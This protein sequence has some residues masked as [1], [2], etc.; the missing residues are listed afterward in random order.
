MKSKIQ[1]KSNIDTMK[2]QN[3]NFIKDKT[4]T[5]KR[6][7]KRKNV[8]AQKNLKAKI[9]NKKNK[10]SKVNKKSNINKINNK[11]NIEDSSTNYLS[12]SNNKNK[13]KNVQKLTNNLTDKIKK[14]IF[15][16]PLLISKESDTE[17]NFINFKLGEKDSYIENTLR[18]ELKNSKNINEKSCP[19]N[20]KKRYNHCDIDKNIGQ[21]ESN[22]FEIYDFNDK[23][24]I[25]YVLRNLSALSSS[26]SGKD[27]SSFN[28]DDFN[29]KEIIDN[30]MQ[31]NQIKI[32]NTK[33]SL[34]QILIQK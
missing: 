9:N 5:E 27:E 32:F 33:H 4:I 22:S 13:K 6:N 8:S 10:E 7:P 29:E 17:S 31:I 16:K 12:G 23:S 14:D 19:N 3:K 15:I 24:N 1:S 25:D 21:N 30:K 2:I 18:S 20:L 34:F 28:V 11:L 26:R